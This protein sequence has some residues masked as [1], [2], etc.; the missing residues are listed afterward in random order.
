MFLSSAGNIRSQRPG[1]R[2]VLTRSGPSAEIVVVPERAHAKSAGVQ[3][4]RDAFRDRVA[5]D[6]V[7]FVE[8][9]GALSAV[10]V[11]AKVSSRARDVSQRTAVWGRMNAR[12]LR[13]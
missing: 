12:P 3:G 13:D 4:V 9:Q 7:E 10:N 11:P 6:N 2:P 8:D 5:P 1:A